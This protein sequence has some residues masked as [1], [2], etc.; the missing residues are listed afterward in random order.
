[1]YNLR[2][3]RKDHGRSW[4]S[5]FFRQRLIRL[6]ASE[7]PE[8]LVGLDEQ[9]AE[10][11]RELVRISWYMRGGVTMQELLHIYSHDDRE[12]MYAII[13]DNLETTKESGMPFV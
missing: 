2:Q 3:G 12:S 1:M 8:Y 6:S 10:F 7:I 9:V 5:K 11:K 4:S 13:K